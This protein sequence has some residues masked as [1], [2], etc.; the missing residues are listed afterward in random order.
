VSVAVD[1][2]HC[3]L[4]VCS[5]HTPGGSQF[6]VQNNVF[7]GGE[8]FA[9]FG[10]GGK[11]RRRKVHSA[12]A[13]DAFFGKGKPAFASKIIGQLL[14]ETIYQVCALLALS[15]VLAAMRQSRRKHQLKRVEGG[16]GEVCVKNDRR[17][18]HSS[19]FSVAKRVKKG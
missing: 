2:L 19:P 5:T 11:K 8:I 3:T 16:G 7:E 6:E 10:S 17:E 4:L 15:F 9:Q 13:K 18:S 1:V 14:L 12:H